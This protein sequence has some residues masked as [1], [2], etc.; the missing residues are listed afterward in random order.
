MADPDQWRHGG[1]R[2][3]AE[4]RPDR[5]KGTGKSWALH[6]HDIAKAQDA[7][8][9]DQPDPGKFYMGYPYPRSWGR[10]VERYVSPRDNP[11]PHA[12][13]FPQGQASPIANLTISWPG[14]SRSD[15]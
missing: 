3:D 5:S 13:Y 9:P 14:K 10:V 6:C 1:D 11:S 7:I 8:H 4:P 15:G 2:F 12:P